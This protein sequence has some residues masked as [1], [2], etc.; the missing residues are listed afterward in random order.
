VRSIFTFGSD[1]RALGWRR[2]GCGRRWVRCVFAWS[3]LV[4]PA[5]FAGMLPRSACAAGVAGGGA[6]VRRVDARHGFY[7]G[8]VVA[9]IWV[10][11]LR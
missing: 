6:V 1:I 8:A 9:A 11:V 10:S 4:C 5:W 3:L 7:G 2:C